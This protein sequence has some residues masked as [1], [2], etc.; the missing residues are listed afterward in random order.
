MEELNIK[1]RNT[2]KIIFSP[3]HFWEEVINDKLFSSLEKAD[4]I[5]KKAIKNFGIFIEPI[6]PRNDCNFLCIFKSD[7]GK[8]VCCPV[9]CLKFGQLFIPTIYPANQWQ[10][11][12]YN[13]IIKKKQNKLKK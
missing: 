6:F 3:K 10:S 13:E 11:D 4:I 12:A 7:L 5:T 2:R 1:D 8:L 9:R